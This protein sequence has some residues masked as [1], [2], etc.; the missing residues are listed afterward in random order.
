MREVVHDRTYRYKTHMHD[1]LFMPG[2]TFPETIPKVVHEDVSMTGS[3]MPNTTIQ[4]GPTIQEMTEKYTHGFVHN[5]ICRC[6]QHSRH[7]VCKTEYSK[8]DSRC[9]RALVLEWFEIFSQRLSCSSLTEGSQLDLD[10]LC[11]FKNLVHASSM[12]F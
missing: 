1:S 8:F 11:M 10:S 5:G 2:L 7:L 3:T 12:R 6:K 9:P 4:Q